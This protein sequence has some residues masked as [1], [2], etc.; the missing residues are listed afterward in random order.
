[1]KAWNDLC[2]CPDRSPLLFPEL[3]AGGICTNAGLPASPFRIVIKKKPALL[4]IDAE[5]NFE[6]F[7]HKDSIDY[8]L[9]NQIAGLFANRGCRHSSD[10]RGSLYM[11][12]YA[13]QMKEWNGAKAGDFDHLG[14]FIMKVARTGAGDTRLIE[15]ILC[16]HNYFDRGMAYMRTSGM[17]FRWCPIS[18]K[19]ITPITE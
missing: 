10:H 15:C 7:S 4:W 1:M 18:D 13:P 6:R 3:Y 5:A 19:G 11:C 2:K 9:E 16:R 12:E 8:Y 17:G 14:Y